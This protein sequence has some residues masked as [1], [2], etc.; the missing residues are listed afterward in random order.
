MKR[1]AIKRLAYYGLVTRDIL[2]GNEEFDGNL[3]DYEILC[4][5]HEIGKTEWCADR[6]CLYKLNSQ[7]QLTYRIVVETFYQYQ[8]SWYDNFFDVIKRILRI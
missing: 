4:A 1:I 5:I 3:S 7:G 8:K 6:S 2:Y